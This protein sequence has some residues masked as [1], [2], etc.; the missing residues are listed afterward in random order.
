[1]A[2][3]P[4][5]VLFQPI[6]EAAWTDLERIAAAS[7]GLPTTDW[8]LISPEWNLLVINA[9]MLES[10]GVQSIERYRGM[11]LGYATGDALS[12]L[13]IETYN[14]P[15]LPATF[16][17][18]VGDLYNSTGT[19]YTIDAGDYM[20]V[21]PSSRDDIT[22]KI[23]GPLSI[24]PGASAGILARANT[25]GSVGSAVPGEIDVIESAGFGG[26]TFVNTSTA[27][28]RDI[29]SD[30]DLEK[31]ARLGMTPLSVGGP[32][33]AYAYFAQGGERSGAIDADIAAIGVNRV[34][35]TL[36]DL[37]GTV[38]VYYATISGAVAGTETTGDLGLINAKIK[39]RVR[40]PG[41][42]YVGLSA[43]P[44][45]VDFDGVVYVREA[46][47]VDEV[48]LIAAITQVLTDYV[49]ASPIGGY[50]EITPTP[51]YTG[52]ITVS[53]TRGFF[54]NPPGFDAGTVS[55]ATSSVNGGG[56][57]LFAIDEVPVMG[58]VTISVTY[59]PEQAP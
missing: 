24:P 10:L 51:G 43:T 6:L 15:R 22:Y 25:A 4:I 27:T 57:Q 38:T 5:T 31:R 32:R 39:L 19:T 47:G 35:V 41:V 16:A 37:T 55:D 44:V 20:T 3:D 46:L 14:T 18:C 52:S 29:E 17:T 34:S 48:V 23:E 56:E 50:P 40:P 54:T 28:G 9:R 11:F 21:K 30:I 33:D 7:L 13:A 59:Q 26:V 2:G 12:I 45:T 42:D 58:A 53:K 49:N 8:S 1:M 36:D